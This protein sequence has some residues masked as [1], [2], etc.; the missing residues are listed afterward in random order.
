MAIVYTIQNYGFDLQAITETFPEGAV[1]C[2]STGADSEDFPN[3]TSDYPTKYLNRAISIASTRGLRKVVALDS[4]QLADNCAAGIVEGRSWGYSPAATID[5]NL[6]YAIG[7]RI[8]NASIVNMDNVNSI[9]NEFDKCFFMD[10]AY[11]FGKYATIRN[12]WIQN[13][14][15]STIVIKDQSVSLLEKSVLGMNSGTRKAVILDC[16]GLGAGNLVIAKC[17]G[18]LKIINLTSALGN[19]S[20][21]IQDFTGTVEL[22]SSCTGSNTYITFD[23]GKGELIDNSAGTNVAGKD[24]FL[25][26]PDVA[27][28]TAADIWTYATRELT[29]GTRDAEIDSI[30]TTVEALPSDDDI[31]TNILES[32]VDVKFPTGATETLQVGQLLSMVASVSSPRAKIVGS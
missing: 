28:P 13:T 3:G 9:G 24:T 5:F 22:D 32:T 29:A 20:I 31:V 17:S 15:G 7:L 14:S 27:I 23:G 30:K 19:Y 1:F 10:S 26:I 18:Y 4:V 21:H 2:E 11:N 8:R 6:K 12:S 25:N 16:A